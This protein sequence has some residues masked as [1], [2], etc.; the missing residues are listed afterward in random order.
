MLALAFAL[1]AL[2]GVLRNRFLYAEFFKCCLLEL[3]AYN[4]AF[5]IPD[6]IFKLLVTGAL[7]ASFIPVFSS[8]LKKDPK[9]ANQFASA[10]INILLIGFFIVGVLAFIFV[11]PLSQLITNGFNP[12]QLAL[13]ARL[14]RILILGQLFF[15]L[16]NF[17]TAILQVNQIFFIPA[18]SPLIY[19]T[20]VILSIIF[21][22]PHFGF[23]GVAW[24]TVAG[25]LL[26]F[27]IQLPSLVKTGYLYHPVLTF[28]SGSVV[29]VFRLMIPRTLSLG[30]NE[31]ESTATLFFATSLASGSLSIFN[32]ALQIIFLPSRVFST[33]V[34]QAA[35]PTLSRKVA[36]N[37]SA[38]FLLIVKKT[39]FQSLFLVLPITVILLVNRLAVVR[40]LF[41][42]RDFPW[43][44][45]L[46]TAKTLAFLL[47]II[48]AQT[49]IQILNR[50]FY[51]LHDTITPFKIAA[52]SLLAN[53]SSAWYL[54]NF[55]T[56][57]ILG[58]A[59]SVS[60]GNVVQTVALSLM[61]YRRFPG[62]NLAKLVSKLFKLIIASLVA[63]VFSWLLLQTLDNLLRGT[64]KTWMVAFNLSVSSLGGLV[65]FF[66]VCWFF[67]IS[68][69]DYYR[70]KWISLRLKF[71]K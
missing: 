19:N 42:S 71:Q 18:L 53:I 33:T 13:M 22:A 36:A 44:A 68:E 48:P 9:A 2:L 29:E 26:H 38:G 25:A 69:V 15:L 45:T 56:L 20:S 11:H 62:H 50:S 28:S 5:R 52:I 7:S 61:F 46:Q 64:V 35:L 54:V 12:E 65:V 60:I 40:L 31:I 47:P 10:I 1:S 49:V 51:A 55:T 6:L 41:G 57:G 32:L 27:L 23:E 34:G 67:R 14:S 66:V 4:A 43:S 63:S 3:D 58:L 59:L 8:Q 21:L 16:S 37:N 24:G 30:L 39:I 70:Q 17:V